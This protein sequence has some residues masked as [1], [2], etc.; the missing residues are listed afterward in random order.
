MNRWYLVNHRHEADRSGPEEAARKNW[1]LQ[2]MI[3]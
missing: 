2:V 3:S 1:F